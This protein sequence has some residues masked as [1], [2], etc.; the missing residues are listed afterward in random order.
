MKL[1]TLALTLF[2]V[3]VHGQA[4]T[5][6]TEDGVIVEA[7]SETGGVESTDTE[8]E[9]DTTSVQ[10]STSVTSSPSPT[11]QEPEEPEFPVDFSTVES[12]LRT[13]IF[14]GDVEEAAEVLRSSRVISLGAGLT[15]PDDL[16]RLVD[17]SS[18]RNE[19]P[20]VVAFKA[21]AVNALDT[22]EATKLAQAVVL[23][24]QPDCQCSALSAD[25][26][27]DILEA[28][29][30]DFT[31]KEELQQIVDADANEDFEPTP[32]R[33]L[34]QTGKSPVNSFVCAYCWPKKQCRKMHW[35]RN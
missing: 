4:T 25:E 22:D 31:N 17:Q 10:V 18:N 24:F 16:V 11:P 8:V 33:R 9:T 7:T 6:I 3:G 13:R 19:D 28:F 27:D 12:S 34:Y 14:Q 5:E 1:L 23:S 20:D 15:Y 32:L 30:M 21:L 26:A 29:R 2:L 35:C